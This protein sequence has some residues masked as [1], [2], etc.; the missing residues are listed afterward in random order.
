M[1]NFYPKKSIFSVFMALNSRF[2]RD[3]R[4]FR[5]LQTH[6]KPNRLN[7]IATHKQNRPLYLFRAAPRAWKI[8][9]KISHTCTCAALVV[10]ARMLASSQAR[11]A[12]K[13]A[14]YGLAQL[15]GIEGAKRRA[16][17]CPAW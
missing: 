6:Q 2:C 12:Q 11:H 13:A 10:G 15:L 5:S 9:R 17:D 3:F 14:L 1:V 16:S 8:K 7:C 4:R